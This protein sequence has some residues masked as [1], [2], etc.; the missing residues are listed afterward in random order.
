MD[1]HIARSQQ[2][3][4]CDKASESTARLNSETKLLS[5]TPL[6]GCDAQPQRAR[7]EA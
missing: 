2:D 3:C 6:H 1:L 7:P 5:A 4:C